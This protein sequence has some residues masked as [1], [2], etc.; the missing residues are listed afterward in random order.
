[1]DRLLTMKEVA[2]VTG[3]PLW[4][5]YLYGRRSVEDGG[6]AVVRIG[7]HVKVKETALQEWIDKNEVR[8]GLHTRSTQPLRAGLPGP[9]GEEK[10]AE[11]SV[12]R[13]R[14]ARR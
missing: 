3:F 13:R 6:F 4:T 12:H 9:V 11:L 2:E 8:T 10:L 1:M 7:R 5:C 14:Q